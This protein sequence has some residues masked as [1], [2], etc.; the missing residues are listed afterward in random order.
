[1][2]IAVIVIYTF[3]IT[4]LFFYCLM[5]LSLALHYI[6][7]KKS[8]E[9]NPEEIKF[10]IP[11]NEYPFV[12]IQLPI[13]NELYVVERLIDA[14]AEFDYPKDKLEIQVLDDSTDETVD[15]ISNKVKEWKEKGMQIFHIRRA[16]RIGF[17]AGALQEGSQI[18]KGEFIAIFDA[19]FAPYPDFL[20]KT[21]PYFLLDEHVG[22]VQTKWEHLNKN[23]SILTK[24]QAFALDMH[25]TIE[26]TGRN[27]AGYFINFNGT[28]GVWRKATIDDAGGW[29]SDTLTEDLDLS[30]RAQLKGWKFKYVEGIS[31]PSELPTDMNAVKSQQFRWNKGGAETARKMGRSVLRSE[32]PLRVKLH[33]IAHLFNTTNYIFI[34]ITAILSVP[35]LFIKNVEIE[36]NYFKYASVFL[37]GSIAIAYSYYISTQQSEKTSRRTWRVFLARFPVFLAITMGLSLHNAW[38]VFKGWRGQRTAFVRTPKFNVISSKDIW[39]NKKYIS[40]KIG[41]ITYLEGLFMLYFLSG[42][43]MGVYYGDYGLFPFHLIAATGFGII[44]Y[45]SLKHSRL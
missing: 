18:A 39:K 20:L 11:E 34:F 24:M 25:F 29:M 28:A 3:A 13:Y 36:F 32:L 43:I 15:L 6:K 41:V 31:S 35:L 44:F 45:F 14:V 42:M 12:T 33:A 17:K 8:L 16:N 22:V 1:M 37:I 26:Q 38:A 7:F 23:Y 10:H 19:D 4:F 21:I 2:S 30:Y 27:A 9:E 5:Q 40:R